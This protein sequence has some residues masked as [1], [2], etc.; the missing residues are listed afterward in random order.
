MVRRVA[1]DAGQSHVDAVYVGRADR[2][3]LRLPGVGG[4]LS[5]ERAAERVGRRL[6]TVV[7][8]VSDGQ[9]IDQVLVGLSGFDS[10]GVLAAGVARAIGE[11]TGARDVAV[12]SDGRAWYLGS[13]GW[14]AGALA[15]VGTGTVVIASDGRSRWHQVDGWGHLLGDEGSAF[16]IGRAGLVDALRAY[17]GR[18]GSPSLLKAMID[19]YGSPHRLAAIIYGSRA[20][21]KD[22]ASF[23]NMVTKA[24][25]EGDA[26]ATAIVRQAGT[27]VG[28]AIVAAC[29]NVFDDAPD[30]PVVVG[31]ALATSGDLF[32]DSIRLAVR[33]SEPQ[34]HPV[35][36]QADPLTGV[37]KL[38]ETSA[39]FPSMLAVRWHK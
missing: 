1:I 17:D 23:A 32:I 39:Q 38:G 3:T 22:V 18:G 31:G 28:L 30:I 10:G 24:A 33:A 35:V 25:M 20:I 2:R 19:R 34:L 4:W 21:T 9:P 14:A 37:L 13:I 12:A 36:T 8:R 5:D 16:A 7:N 11:R 15:A 29:R 26:G 27:S 6:V